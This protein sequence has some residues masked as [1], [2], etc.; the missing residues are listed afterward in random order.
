MEKEKLTTALFEDF[1]KNPGSHCEVNRILFS[2]KACRKHGH[3]L[4]HVYYE[5]T[6]RE[7]PIILQVLLSNYYVPGT[8]LDARD[9]VVNKQS[10]CSHW[11]Y[12]LLRG[13]KQIST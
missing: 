5:N 12:I 4:C 11:V 6:L 9:T 10:P 13:N 2:L 1:L 8:V 7:I 3:S